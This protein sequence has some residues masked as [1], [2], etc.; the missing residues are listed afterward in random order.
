MCSWWREALTQLTQ[1][2]LQYVVPDCSSA[3]LASPFTVINCFSTGEKKIFTWFW[4]SFIRYTLLIT[5]SMA[6]TELFCN[7]SFLHHNLS[8]TD[9]LKLLKLKQQVQA[10]KDKLAH[11]SFPWSLFMSMTVSR[12]QRGNLN[13]A[14]AERMNWRSKGN[15]I[16]ILEG[17]N[18]VIQRSS[19]TFHN[20]FTCCFKE[21]CKVLL[22]YFM[23]PK[24]PAVEAEAFSLTS[25]YRTGCGGLSL[26]VPN[27][28]SKSTH[29]V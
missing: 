1:S 24:L 4:V 20:F 19:A 18:V 15:K 27:H 28:L 23:I 26:I 17:K 9:N 7:Y 16:W 14:K 8:E 6:K 3:K 22:I 21:R 25:Q 10:D 5:V 29:N 2:R 12:S 11:Y 13:D